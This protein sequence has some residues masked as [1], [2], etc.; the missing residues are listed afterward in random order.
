MYRTTLRLTSM[1]TVAI[2]L[3]GCGTEGETPADQPPTTAS[4]STGS[5]LSSSP[6]PSPTPTGPVIRVN[7]RGSKV[8]PV[9][10]RIN[11]KVNEPVT[12]IVT[13]DRPGGLHV[14]SSP[15]QSP[16]FQAGTTTLSV[17]IDKPGIVE[18][19]EHESDAIVVQLEVR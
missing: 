16:E 11:A 2:F 13:A 6:D 12:F 8:S 10:E 1:A 19:E 14:H 3:S 9:A 7:I 18:V 5:P 15:E 17:T 4:T